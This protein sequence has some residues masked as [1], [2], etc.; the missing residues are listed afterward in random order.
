MPKQ[1]ILDSHIHL[2]PSSAANNESHAW[3]NKGDHLAKQYSISEYL[4][5]SSPS[6]TPSSREPANYE[7]KGFVYVETDRRYRRELAEGEDVCEFKWAEQ[8]YAENAFLMRII[9]RLRAEG[10]G[11]D[12]GFDGETA[13]LMRGCVVWAPVDRGLDVF[14]RWLD[15][16]H[17]TGLQWVKGFRYLLQGI[18]DKGEFERVVMDAGFVDVLGFMGR[19]GW[20]FDVGVDQ[21]QGGNWQLEFIP[22]LIARVHEGVVGDREKTV[23]V[24]SMCVVFFCFEVMATLTTDDVVD[25]LCK[26]DMEDSLDNNPDTKALFELW[27]LSITR[28]AACEKTYM[29]LS[30]AFS[31]IADQ[32]PNHP[33]PVSKIVER[34]RPWLEHVLQTFT[35]QRIMFG[36]DWPVCNVRGPGDAKSWGHWRSVVEASLEEQGLS[37][38]QKDRIWYGTAEEVYKLEKEPVYG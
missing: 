28:L 23:F 24:L 29:K 31:E 12:E 15:V 20:C 21:R 22:G 13:G 25:H 4:A 3:M 16:E 11:V 10:V 34:I 1:R 37:E 14:R 17:S 30:G 18:R 27:K 35:P 5:A 8:C 2:W 32:D 7:V 9:R 6:P 36:S 33:W 26:P 19:E 38:L